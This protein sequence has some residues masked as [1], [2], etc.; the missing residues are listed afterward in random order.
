MA[1]MGEE[2]SEVK[3]TADQKEQ[4]GTPN[5]C[6][7]HLVDSQDLRENIQWTDETNV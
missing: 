5:I 2:S 7:K 1:S 3:T 6:I 4:T